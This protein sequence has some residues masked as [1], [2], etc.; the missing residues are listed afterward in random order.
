MQPAVP[1]TVHYQQH[2]SSMH[3]TTCSTMLCLH[4][5]DLLSTTVHFNGP[6]APLLASY[7]PGNTYMPRD[8]SLTRAQQ[9]DDV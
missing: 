8:F 6:R 9:M 4:P 3:P 2:S 1:F 5:D 7:P